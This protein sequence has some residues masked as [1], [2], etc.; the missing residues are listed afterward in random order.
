V[1]L[2]S[3]EAGVLELDRSF[4]AQSHENEEDLAIAASVVGLGRALGLSVVAG[5]VET[6]AQLAVLQQLPCMAGQ[7]HLWH[8]GVSSE[9]LAEAVRQVRQMAPDRQTWPLRLWDR[10][11]AMDV[12][13]GE[14]AAPPI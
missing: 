13:A 10:S 6:A 9:E 2:D 7:G 1:G 8:H 12:S 11:V 3:G 5:G 14:R 4:V